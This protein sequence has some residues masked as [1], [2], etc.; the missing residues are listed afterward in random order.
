[1]QLIGDVAELVRVEGLNSNEFSYV[2]FDL[3]LTTSDWGAICSHKAQ[4]GA[5]WP[6]AAKRLQEFFTW[7]VSHHERL[8]GPIELGPAERHRR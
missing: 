2:T 6:T 4:T 3:Q 8:Y 1:L 5:F 7:V